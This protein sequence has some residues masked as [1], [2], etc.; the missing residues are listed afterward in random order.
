MERNEFI[1]G[2][3]IAKGGQKVVYSAVNKNDPKK[4]AVIK[5]AQ[6]NS[7]ASLQRILREVNF[8]CSLDSPYFPKQDGN[9]TTH[10]GYE[11]YDYDRHR[12]VH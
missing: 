5:D 2:D 10:T 7:T 9:M 4:K 12:G 8:L 3:Q 11:N 1:I 6:I